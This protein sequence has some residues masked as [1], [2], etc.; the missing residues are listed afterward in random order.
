MTNAKLNQA[1]A[2]AAALEK[3]GFRSDEPENA[4]VALPTARKAFLICNP[5][6]TQSD[7]E[8][9]YVSLIHDHVPNTAYY[10]ILG[11]LCHRALRRPHVPQERRDE[12][13]YAWGYYDALWHEEL[14][15]AQ[16]GSDKADEKI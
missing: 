9:L 8:E 12:M 16:K 10:R 1:E 6:T 15:H 5:G 13:A 2:L 11:E 14:L 7:W 3:G 4:P